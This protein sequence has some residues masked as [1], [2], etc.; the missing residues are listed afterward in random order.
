MSLPFSQNLFTLGD[1]EGTGFLNYVEDN[2]IKHP[3]AS[4]LQELVLLVCATM[5][6]LCNAEE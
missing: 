1:G 4:A 5:A 2:N 3:P 6:G